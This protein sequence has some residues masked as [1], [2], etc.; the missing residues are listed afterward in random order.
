MPYGMGDNIQ[1]IVVL[2]TVYVGGGGAADVNDDLTVMAYDTCSCD[3]T[4]LPPYRIH[5][6]AMT[7]IN[8]QLVLVGGEKH[9]QYSKMLGVWKAEGKEWTHPYPEM[10]T[11][12]SRSSAVTY[13]KWLAVA[14]G[15]GDGRMRLRVVEVMNTDNKQW[16]TG[17]STP[18]PWSGMKTAIVGETCYFMGGYTPVQGGFRSRPQYYPTA[19][20]YSV[21]L[22]A[23]TTPIHPQSEVWKEASGLQTT[24][25][26]PLTIS[27]SLFT[28][29]G[30]DGNAATAIHLYQPD[31]G[32]WMK[33]GDLPTPQYR[34]TC[35][36]ITKREIFVSG[37]HGPDTHSV[38]R[39]DIAL[40]Y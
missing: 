22:P 21:S 8:Y 30:W 2:G 15:L 16:F 11:A 23:L 6:F 33:V 36:M 25:S 24:H 18:I 40:F 20:V 14:G 17:I 35:A 38:S 31:T 4:K 10:P 19:K 39:M 5:C 34:C 1:S 32:E 9:G 13:N 28:V 27:G 7:V 26:T 3:W 12:R 37:G 29:G